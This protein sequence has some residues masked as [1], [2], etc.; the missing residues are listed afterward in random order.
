MDEE[1]V[2]EFLTNDYPKLLSKAIDIIKI[3]AA[4]SGAAPISGKVTNIKIASGK[5]EC[6]V[7]DNKLTSNAYRGIFR[8]PKEWL[9]KSFDVI[10][11]ERKEIIKQE[12]RR[13]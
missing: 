5:A 4:L 8:F 12:N 2:L 6:L 9:F 7:Y 10:I 1:E 13:L 3:D 11:A